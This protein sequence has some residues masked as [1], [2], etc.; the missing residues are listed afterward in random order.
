MS[1]V[2]CNSMPKSGTHALIRAVE[3]LGLPDVQLAHAAYGQLDPTAGK[4]LYII[5]DPRNNLISRTRAS[6]YPLT[7]GSLMLK[8][9]NFEDGLSYRDYAAGFFSWIDDPAT[10]VVRFEALIGD[11][12]AT[13]RGIADFLGVPYLDDA[14]P[15]I[16]GPTVTWTGQL[17]DWRSEPA[18]TPVVEEAFQAE[19]GA[20]VAARYGYG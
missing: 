4:H 9:R 7:Q 17:S 20:E 12:G 18:W 3:L 10:H 1:P 6:A 8:L 5:R 16:I 13:L 2:I 19:G 15:H 14:Y 11:G